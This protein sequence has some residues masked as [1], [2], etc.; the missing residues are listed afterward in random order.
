MQSSKNEKAYHL[1]HYPHQRLYQTRNLAGNLHPHRS[2]GK[3]KRQGLCDITG[4]DFHHR[5]PADRIRKRRHK[6]EEYT[7]NK[8]KE[9]GFRMFN[10]REFQ[11]EASVARNR[12]IDHRR[13]FRESSNHRSFT[14]SSR[15][16]WRWSRYGG[17]DRNGLLNKTRGCE[18]KLALIYIG[19]L[20]A[21]RKKPP[22]STGAKNSYYY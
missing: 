8:F 1:Q 7:F 11:V 22:T 13:R 21:A 10:I 4:N 15:C 19:I 18:S 2:G 12:F 20:E 16:N 6:V 9:Y 3:T 14:H 5:S 17:M